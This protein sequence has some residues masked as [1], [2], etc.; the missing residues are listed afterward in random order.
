MININGVVYTTLQDLQAYLDQSN[1]SEYQK[2]VLIND[3]NGV[4][5]E[6]IEEIKH[7]VT[8]LIHHNF[9][10]LD[11]SKVDFTIHLK[12]NTVL[13]KKVDMLPNGRP[14]VAKYYYPTVAPEN[15]IC[16]IDFEFVDNSMKF[17]VERREFLKYY[18]TDGTFSGP[19]LIHKRIYD[20]VN[21]KEA[22]ESIQER[23]QARR[24]IIDE[25][26]V[27]LNGF[28]VQKSMMEGQSATDA[29]ITAMV[30]GGTFMQLH[31]AKLDAWIET[32][33]GDLK[34]YLLNANADTQEP[35]LDWLVQPNVK[36]R[37]Y[38]LNRISY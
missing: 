38:F 8:D 34:P 31:K 4:P 2:Q 11:I 13:I 27:F 1:L 37:D 22:T 30:I 6:P 20:F 26:K 35:F 5:N 21:L 23:S 7:K 36:V 17:M 25:V 14:I 28:I 32:A 24:N 18:K 10:G 16:S 12:E 29:N 19:F 9:V 3:F 15:L 33:A